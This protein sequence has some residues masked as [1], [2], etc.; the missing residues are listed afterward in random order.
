[1]GPLS[2]GIATV[3]NSILKIFG[4]GCL[5]L[6]LLNVSPLHA[7]PMPLPSVAYSAEGV[8]EFDNTTI[9]QKI[10]HTQDKERRELKLQGQ[11]QTMILRY[12]LG[13]LYMFMP[14]QPMVM[15][16]SLDPKM[17]S[18]QDAM[19][20]IEVNAEGEETVAG[21]SA[22]KYRMSGQDL[23]GNSTEGT[24]WVSDDGILLRMEATSMI[25]GVATPMRYELS[26]V[27]IGEPDPQ[28]FEVPTNAQ[29]IKVN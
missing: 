13:R 23:L 20:N 9:P 28:L 7:E 25:D 26:K 11:E 17:A 14:D 22:T 19:K 16:M 24:A 4:I 21:L 1:M 27:E 18:P 15:D 29:I 12:D 2:A 5:A 10:W 6:G 8:M 3:R